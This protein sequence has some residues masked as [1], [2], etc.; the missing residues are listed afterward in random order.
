VCL[1]LTLAVTR[2]YPGRPC[3]VH[4]RWTGHVTP[5]V[6]SRIPRARCVLRSGPTHSGREYE[7]RTLGDSHA[8]RL[9][10]HVG[11]GGDKFVAAV[12]GGAYRASSATR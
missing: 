3:S 9:H 4:T 11:M 8:W 6:V 7:I 5:P 12:G 2:A 1:V 10:R